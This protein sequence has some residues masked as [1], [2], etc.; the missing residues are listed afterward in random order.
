MKINELIDRVEN[1]FL[2]LGFS[3]V[4][5]GEKQLRYFRYKDCY[6]R[7]ASLEE[8][9]AIVIESADNMVDAENQL[10]EDGELYYLDTPEKSLLS[11]IE[12]DINMYYM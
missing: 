1:I 2:R 11:Q 7:V 12:E 3:P 8:W 10:L 9:N 6:C 5:V 4:F